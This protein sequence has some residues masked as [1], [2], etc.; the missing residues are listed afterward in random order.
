[1]KGVISVFRSKILKLHTT[2]SWDFLGLTLDSS[3]VSLL[4]L[5]YGYDSV[6]GVFDTGVLLSL[7]VKASFSCFASVIKEN[8]FTTYSREKKIHII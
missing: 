5:T 8:Q 2:R 1:M 3:E 4:Q 7:L 6:V